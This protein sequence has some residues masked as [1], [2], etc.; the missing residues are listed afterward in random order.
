MPR[1]GAM[2]AARGWYDSPA[3]REILPLRTR[4]I[5]GDLLLIDGVP[6]G[7]EAAATAAHLR[8][9]QAEQEA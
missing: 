5:A 1:A 2:D 8:A 6:E 3:Y 4:H 7:Y 9:A